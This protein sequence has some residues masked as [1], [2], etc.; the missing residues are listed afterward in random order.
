[1]GPR[2]WLWLGTVLDLLVLLPAFYMAIAAVDAV[3]RSDLSA[4]SVVVAAL[5]FALPVFCIASPLAGWRAAKRGGSALHVASLFA[6][7]LVF[8]AF[9]ILF[10]YSS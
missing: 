4:F 10:L 5:F 3:S 9:L 1:M 2:A 6:S 7:P 8:G